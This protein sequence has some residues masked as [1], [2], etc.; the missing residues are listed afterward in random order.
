M[1]RR[2]AERQPKRV[3]VRFWRHG[4][5]QPHSGFTVDLS[6]TGLFL[7]TSVPLTPRERIRLEVLDHDHGFMV[8]AEVA[9]VHKV[10][11]A[12]RHVQQPGVGVRF[13]T[14]T[15]LVGTMMSQG[16][17]APQRTRAVREIA[18]GAGAEEE[19]PRPAPAAEPRPPD[20]IEDL[21]GEA[22]PAAETEPV[23]AASAGEAAPPKPAPP[24]EAAEPLREQKTV[25]VEFVD[26]AS[27]LS[28]YQRD[29]AAGGLFVTT[30]H[31]AP[32]H[33]TVTIE[34]RPPVASVRPLRFEA[35]VVHRFEPGAAGAGPGMHGIGVQFFDPERVCA[36][37]A[38]VLEALRK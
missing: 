26:R 12:L 36:D 31:L 22:P 30:E 19:A 21:F 29:I 17:A 5:P 27:F 16:K 37:L 25:P 14:P 1:T 15:E 32:L 34:L 23:A 9:R 4:S 35:R 3:E 8:E 24:G 18:P 38:P 28:V 6:R 20:E 2:S 10:A 11:L 33:A 13:L 7:G